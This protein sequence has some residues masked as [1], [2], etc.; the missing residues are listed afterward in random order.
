[1]LDKFKNI[2]F[3][4]IVVAAAV[5][6]AGVFVGGAVGINISKT[7]SG[8]NVTV[9]SSFD[10]ELAGEQV[11]TLVENE[12]GTVEEV[13]AATVV[14]VEGDELGEECGEGE[15]CG[16]GSYAPTE[17]PQAFRD[18]TINKCW[19]EDGH[20]G[21]QCWDLGQL[22]WTNYAGR[23]LSTCG[24][25]AAKGIWNCK[26]QNAGDEFELITDATQ[27]QA[28]DWVIFNNGKYGHVGMALGDYN[29]GYVSLL[30]T[31]QG[32]SSCSGGGSAAN[33]INI[34]LAHFSG[35]FR[36]KTYI[37]EEPEPEPEEEPAE[38]ESNTI[39]Y[40]YVKGDQFGKILKKLGLAT[41]S[42]L[43]GKNGKVAYYNAQLL[44]Q[45]IL[46]YY[47][48]KYW[49]DIPVGTTITLTKEQ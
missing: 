49:N 30:G 37:V 27:L 10:I 40:T 46:N 5:T 35:A 9:N 44:E 6:V 7:D 2:N 22:F 32:G 28:G 18:Y 36:P 8:T 14:A 39:T 16:Q 31:N 19:D 24:T 11:P 47:G 23:T 1:M 26:E 13:D 48:G 45:G 29:N 20:Y 33:I 43:W 38:E 25:G 42:N 41:D 3:G 21:S 4:K 12:D 15:E 34:S 17:T